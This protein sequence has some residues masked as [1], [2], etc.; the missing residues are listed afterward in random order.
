METNKPNLISN[1]E[2][3]HTEGGKKKTNLSNFWTL[4]LDYVLRI[5]TKRTRNKH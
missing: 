3:N 5:K 4:H 1:E 2:H